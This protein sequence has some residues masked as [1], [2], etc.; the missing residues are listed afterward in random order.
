MGH[1][2]GSDRESLQSAGAGLGASWQLGSMFYLMLDSGWR[3]YSDTDVAD[4]E[5]QVNP[6]FNGAIVYKW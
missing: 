1:R 4:G 2:V 6:T 5:L 3:M